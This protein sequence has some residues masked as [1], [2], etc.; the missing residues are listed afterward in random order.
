MKGGWDVSHKYNVILDWLKLHFGEMEMEKTSQYLEEN[1]ITFWI[2]EY[3][4]FVT[5]FQTP[6]EIFN[7]HFIF[8][9]KKGKSNTH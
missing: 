2:L 4:S 5:Q 8:A 9:L 7:N 1:E 6:T 3:L